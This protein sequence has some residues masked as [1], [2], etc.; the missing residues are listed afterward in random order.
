[1]YV[2][3]GSKSVGLAWD[4]SKAL[5]ADVGKTAVKT[6]PDGEKHVMVNS[7]VSGSE[8]ILIQSVKSNDDLVELML[9]IDCLKDLGAHQVHT[10]MPYLAYMRQ[11]KV[12]SH[13]EALS[14]KTILK[15]FDELSDSVTTINCH[16]LN[17]GGDAV[18]N[19]IGFRN[20]NAIPDI[21]DYFGKKLG[22]PFFVAPDKGSLAFAKTA[23]HQLDC[24]FDHLSKTRLS[25]SEV[26]IEMKDMNVKGLD[27]VILDD[28]ISTGGTI[29]ESAKVVR[30]GRPAS[31]NVGCVHG[32]FLNGIE[33][34]KGSVD[35][36]V[37][38]DSIENPVSKVSCMDAIV[39]E[40]K[41]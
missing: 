12:F 18:Y 20:L 14:A 27:V 7:N 41:R 19:N 11:D 30:K 13:G 21:V 3:G 34:F 4:V 38:T 31:I 40:F 39:E 33:I 26:E 25:G 17:E 36:L 37:A 22:N 28:I 24:E 35:C 32:L 6:F 8:C 5:K 10:V 16:F 23:A 15:V 1:M 2:F 9:M 29:V